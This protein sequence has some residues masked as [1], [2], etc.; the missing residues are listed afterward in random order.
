MQRLHSRSGDNK[1]PP[2]TPHHL[3]LSLPLSPLSHSDS[4]CLAL[5]GS[6]GI[7]CSLALFSRTLLRLSTLGCVSMA[8]AHSRRPPSS[9]SLSPVSSSAL[10]TQANNFEYGPTHLPDDDHLS[11]APPSPAISRRS[12]QGSISSRHSYSS[13]NSYTGSSNRDSLPQDERSRSSLRSHSPDSN[14]GECAHRM[15][16]APSHVC[17]SARSRS[18]QDCMPSPA[19]HARRCG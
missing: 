17:A 14:S 15:R 4:T 3:P 8:A 9:S 19:P 5:S 13:Y 10:T 2:L 18:E 12:T 16:C 11:H 7:P 6:I 1:G